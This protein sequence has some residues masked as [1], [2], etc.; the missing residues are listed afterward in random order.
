MK[1]KLTLFLFVLCGAS[2]F[3]QNVKINAYASYVFDD[4]IDSYY[5]PS[6]YYNGKIK[7]GLLYGAGVEFA[8]KHNSGL[9]LLYLRQDTHAPVNYF[10][11]GAKFTNFELTNNFIMLEKRHTSI[12]SPSGAK[13]DGFLRDGMPA[14]IL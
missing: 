2:A 7:G 3:A 12:F 8:V 1:K 4:S 9:E 6:S 13:F 14:P 5:D 10:L 11:G